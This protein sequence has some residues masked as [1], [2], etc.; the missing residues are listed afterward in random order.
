[1]NGFKKRKKIS[2]GSGE[3]FDFLSYYIEKE[4]LIKGNGLEAKKE[5]INL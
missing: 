3:Y 1:M 4:E 2:I 5:R